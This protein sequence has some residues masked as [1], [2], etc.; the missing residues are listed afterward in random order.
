MKDRK[1]IGGR[2]RHG[3]EVKASYINMRTD[4]DLRGRVEASARARGMSIAQEVER[5]VRKS[6]DSEAA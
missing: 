6:L 5:L 3:E 2:P 4:P 1:G